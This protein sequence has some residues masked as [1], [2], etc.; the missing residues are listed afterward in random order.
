MV[1]ISK[2]TLKN[3]Y[4]SKAKIEK[5]R[6]FDFVILYMMICVWL[7]AYQVWRARNKYNYYNS[8]EDSLSWLV[9]GH[10]LIVL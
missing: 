2:P 5:V 1:I 7:D 4:V 9:K 8:R 6:E 10:G 3:T